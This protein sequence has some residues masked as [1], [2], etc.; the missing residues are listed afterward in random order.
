M[1]CME[2]GQELRILYDGLIYR[3]QA[4]G[5]INRYTANLLGRLPRTFH[6]SLVVGPASAIHFP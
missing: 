3:M 2:S 4:A 1:T 6:P 5:G